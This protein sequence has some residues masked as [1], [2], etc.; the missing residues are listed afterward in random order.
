M[1]AQLKLL[2][3]LQEI[4]SQL[5]RLEATKGD[6]PVREREVRTKRDAL[7][8]QLE[9]LQKELEQTKKDRIRANSEFESLKD[10]KAKYQ[11]QLFTV[12]NNREY[13]AVTAEIELAE[14][15]LEDLETQIIALMEKED[16]L[17]K[18]VE[19]VTS[20]FQT[21]EKE[22]EE[23]L[24]E[25]NEKSAQI[26]DQRLRLMH[27]REKVVMQADKSLIATYERIRRA[28][29][30]LAVVPVSKGAC[31]GC[32]TQIPPQRALEIRSSDRIYTCEVCGRFL[33]W[34]DDSFSDSH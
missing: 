14:K 1:N 5:Q 20:E 9:S 15:A 29:G 3:E 12:R 27:E 11:K 17:T 2:V 33:Y 13:D 16:Q 21:A 34:K 18:E 10:K 6:L 30:G 19:R 8:N 32:F 23:L 28:K 7:K 22:L 25:L 4:D 26:E 24:N 31:G